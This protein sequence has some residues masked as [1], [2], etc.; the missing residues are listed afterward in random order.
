M[1]LLR[2]NSAL[3][4]RFLA[5]IS[6]SDFLLLSAPI[7]N[8]LFIN[9]IPS[10]LNGTLTRMLLFPC[11]TLW[12]FLF[13]YRLCDCLSV[14]NTNSVHSAT[15]APPPPPPASLSAPPYHVSM[16]TISWLTNIMTMSMICILCNC[17][18][19]GFNLAPL[20]SLSLNHSKRLIS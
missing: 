2:E 6:E 3:F 16:I 9:N 20:F 14:R 1:T 12:S 18:F 4:P 8:E 17:D 15:L 11:F 7:H 5:R 19:T 10:I 13:Y